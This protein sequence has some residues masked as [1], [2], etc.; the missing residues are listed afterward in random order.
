[1]IQNAQLWLFHT[2]SHRSPPKWSKMI[3]NAQFWSDKVWG[4]CKMT[5]IGYSES[6]WTTLV[7][8]DWKKCGMAKN[9]HSELF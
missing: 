9:G 5:K 6:F 8:K 3:Q 1:M 2:F 7:G 4:K